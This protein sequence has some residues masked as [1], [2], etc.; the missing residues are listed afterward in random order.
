MLYLALL[1]SI[2]L[3]SRF[4]EA[5][6]WDFDDGTT[7][8]WAAK[9]GA[10]A[11]GSAE[12]NLFP[13]QVKDGVWT[14][15]VSPSVAG[16]KYPTPLVQVVSPTIGYDSGL[17]DRVRV[18]LRTVH[19]R[20]TVGAFLLSWTNEYN[21]TVPGHDPADLFGDRFS[22]IGQAGFVYTT[23]WQEVEITLPE[24]DGEVAPSDREVWE[25]LL[26]DIRLS[27][28]LDW[29]ERNVP[30]SAAE[31]VGWLEID[32]IELT[33][34]EELLLGELA[35]PSVE[36]FHFEGAKLFAPP[37]F[38]PIAP[39][40]G[41][42]GVLTDLDA[43]G[44]LDL[45]S[46]WNGRGPGSDN[47]FVNGWVMAL[48]DGQGTFEKVHTE[49]I[50]WMTYLNVRSGDLTGDGQDEIVFATSDIAVWSIEPDLQIE[51][52]TQLPDRRLVGLMDW[53]GD[54]EIELFSYH[55]VA[56]G[57]ALEVW[58][59]EHG[60]W[61][62]TPLVVA[63]NHAPS[64]IG[65]F[66]GDGGLEVL[67][68]QLSSEDNTWI[69]MDLEAAPGEGDPLLEADIRN[70]PFARPLQVGD[71]DDDGQMDLL[72][73]VEHNLFEGTKGLLLWRGQS[74]GGVEKT[75]LYDDRLFVRS[76]VVVRDLNGDGVDD[77]TFV[78]GDRASGLGVFVEWGG[79]ANPA[80][81]VER[82]RLAGEGSQVLPGD[83]DGDGDLDLVVFNRILGGVQVLKSSVGEQRTAVLTPEVARPA[84]HRLGDSYPNPFNPAVVIPLE[85]ATDAAEVSLRVYDVL[86]R[87]V[88]QVWQGP[89]GAGTHRFTWDGRN[90][91]GKEVA[92][93]VY[94]YQV[95]V[96]GRVEAKKTTKLP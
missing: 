39:G 85:L 5:I 72:T 66:T 86:G 23:E 93:G 78:G 60:E 89:L 52:L 41:G 69:V 12:F 84:Q 40:L 55:T 67:W 13:G 49:E 94:L 83:V 37:V 82:H 54:G 16:K 90:E 19:H 8:G 88:R 31:V 18:R 42:S 28:S 27:F 38:S 11:G 24:S 9:E 43:D 73:A 35:P 75:V 3:W 50:G 22:L 29:G 74:T 79:G 2:G 58:E 68:E 10:A 91:Q 15:D 25:G 45:F 96:D 61:T 30:R 56:A 1:L 92:A 26:R 59:V 53:D 71:F 34:V 47:P 4:A 63:E 70:M 17:F 65:D 46:I 80:K 57:R 32:W 33:G 7:Q 20:P 81:E 44:D 87:R 95:E 76:R 51:V 36:Y 62:A 14:I 48:N 6:T 21:R 64:R 77:W